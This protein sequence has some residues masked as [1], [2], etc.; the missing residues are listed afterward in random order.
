MT[1]WQTVMLID[2]LEENILK[3]MSQ[4]EQVEMAFRR[5]Y[6]NRLMLG[7]IFIVVILSREKTP[8]P[9]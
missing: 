2:D 4:A 8:T 9:I 6:Y 5:I 1:F 3:A 7:S